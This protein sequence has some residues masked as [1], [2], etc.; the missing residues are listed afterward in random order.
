[1]T[2]PAASVVIPS[3]GGARR[4]P[5]LLAALR[6]QT[7][8]DCEIVVVLD[9]DIDGSAAAVEAA[10]RSGVPVRSVVLP[11]NRGRSAALN[12]GFAEARG[13][14]LIRCDDDLLPAAHFVEAHLR[15]HAEASDPIGVIGLTRNVFSPSP[16]AR[17]YGRARDEKARRAAYLAP[18]DDRWRFWAANVSVTRQVY[19][20]VG[21]YSTDYRQYGWE[22]VDWG[23]RL[24]QAGFTL[25]LAPEVETPHLGAPASTVARLAKAYD[26]GAASVTFMRRHGAGLLDSSWPPA[27][28][29]DQMVFT[30]AAVGGRGALLA[31]GGLADRVADLLPSYVAEKY[32][33]LLVESAALSGRFRSAAETIR[34]V[35][36]SR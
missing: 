25:V 1:M 2:D 12:A 4:L 17:A 7:V 26:S 10:A 9:G 22:D 14:V 30:L 13:S 21:E 20:T 5:S 24:V 3:R 16:Y 6:A 36:V 31:W 23:Y 34:S 18:A 35:A 33:A 28:L 32:V 19:D 11:V 15:R 27:G 8:T 29:W